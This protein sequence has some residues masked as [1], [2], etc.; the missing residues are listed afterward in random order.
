MK[1]FL[2]IKKLTRNEI[3]DLIK[4][5]IDIKKKP[6]KYQDKLKNKTLLLFF[7]APSLRTRVSFEAGM[8]QLGGSAI[9]YDISTSPLGK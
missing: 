9:Y 2:E 3:L 7:E 6:R 8:N 4:K 5:T 1:N